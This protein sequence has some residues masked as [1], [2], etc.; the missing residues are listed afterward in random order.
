MSIWIG[1]VKVMDKCRFYN[2]IA[3]IEKRLKNKKD[4]ELLDTL[5]DIVLE[6]EKE[7]DEMTTEGTMQEEYEKEDLVNSPSHYTSCVKELKIEAIDCMRAAFG[8]KDVSA[9]CICNALKY[10]YRHKSKGGTT[11]ILKAVWYLN[12]YLELNK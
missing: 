7:K 3:S 8:D 12:K 11:D 4:V 6:D 9:F 10:I 1:G 5:V 2:C